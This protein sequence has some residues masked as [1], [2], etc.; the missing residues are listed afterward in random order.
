MWSW[1]EIVCV[2]PCDGCFLLSLL[3]EN[4]NEKQVEHI[5]WLSS[6]SEIVSLQNVWYPHLADRNERLKIGIR[7]KHKK[8]PFSKPPLLHLLGTNRCQKCGQNKCLHVSLHQRH[9]QQ[10]N[11]PRLCECLRYESFSTTK[12]AVSFLHSDTNS[13]AKARTHSGCFDA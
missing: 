7:P 3:P 6:R 9:I 10:V 11:P 8:F 1:Y 4:K 2:N 12:R 5:K 13:E